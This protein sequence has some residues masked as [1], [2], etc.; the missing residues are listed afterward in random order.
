M[1]P[2]ITVKNLD[3]MTQ[4]AP[5]VAV[6]CYLRDSDLLSPV[7][8]RLSFGQATHTE[9][10]VAALLD[11]WVSMLAGCRSV[12]Q[13][14]TRIRPDRVL[15]QAWGREQFAE[16]STIARVLD[17]CQAEQVA[18]LRSGVSQVYRWL[19][20]A[21][22]FMGGSCSHD[23]YRS[24]GFACRTP[25]RRQHTGVFPGKRGRV[26][27]NSDSRI[28]ATDYNE[29]VSSLLYPDNTLSQQV[30]KDAVLTLEAMLPLA[31]AQRRQVCLRIDGGF[32]T[33]PNVNWHLQRNYQVVTKGT[34]GRR[35][36]AW[37]RQGSEWQV[38]VP[39][40]RWIALSPQ[41]HQCCGPT[42]TIALR[43][44]NQQGKLKYSLL[45]VTDLHSSLLE[46][47]QTTIR[48]LPQKSRSAR[49]NRASSHHRKRAWHAQEMLVLFNDLTH[50]FI[51]A[52]RKA[53][54]A[55]TPLADYGLYRLVHEVF[56]VLGQVI[57]VDGQVREL[58][59]L[60]SHPHAQLLTD[61]LPQ[62]WRDF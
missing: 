25:S 8:S 11:L 31:P 7:M 38:V 52:L 18:Q 37:G 54:W 33:D 28:G 16:Q 3:A 61:T 15:A 30:L 20:A 36:S 5:L 9:R 17:G 39:D 13:I 2:H 43:W 12:R 40:Q 49:T 57:M 1:A 56:T 4:F 22:S 53:L 34:A 51:F 26:V 14:N 62:L 59:L 10:P 6:G 23:R 46:L 29:T 19:G 47:S 42:R 45:I 32:G 60:R 35:A 27:G 41:Q 55:H 58:H 24:D 44:R 48:A 50:N 21:P